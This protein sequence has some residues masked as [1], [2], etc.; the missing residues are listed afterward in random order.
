M[1][2][3]RR[4]RPVAEVYDPPAMAFALRDV[5]THIHPGSE[6]ATV[7]LAEKVAA[8][9]GFPAGGRVLDIAS[10]LGG[11]ARVIARR[12]GCSVLC[13]D[14]D[15]RMQAEGQDAAKREG[16][17]LRVQQIL[18]R[19]ERLP[20]ANASCHGSWSQDALCHMDKRAVIAEIARV[21][22][23]GA[24]FAFTDWI[25]LP[26]FS[27]ADRARLAAHWG[28]PDLLSLRQYVDLLEDSG[29]VPLA[30]E[31]RTAANTVS[32][33]A[34]VPDQVEWEDWFVSHYGESELLAQ[35]ARGDAWR[36]VLDGGRAG[37]GTFIAQRR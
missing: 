22:R 26:G 35:A 2:R 32:R 36:E 15:P 5:G 11:P 24:L 16:V 8:F 14:M 33:A 30:A 31:D 27:S 21:L 17:W 19:S 37:Y 25:A 18:A 13:I 28:F 7:Y 23:P 34:E 3:P 1:D 12:F 9:G 4:L 29:F 20:L 6:F 10:A